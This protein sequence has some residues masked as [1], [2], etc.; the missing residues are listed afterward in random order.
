M[1]NGDHSEA[2]A[3]VSTDG[4]DTDTEEC[5]FSTQRTAMR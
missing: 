2:G 5:A 3:S 1:D 4:G